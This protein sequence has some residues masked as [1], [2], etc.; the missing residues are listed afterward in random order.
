[1]FGA[2]ADYCVVEISLVVID[3]TTSRESANDLYIVLATV[4]TIHLRL[5]SLVATHN[6]R[7]VIN[8]E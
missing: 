2:I 6:Y 1:V 7:T 8:V 3:R 5:D 4:D